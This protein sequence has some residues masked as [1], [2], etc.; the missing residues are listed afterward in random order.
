M[1]APWKAVAPGTRKAGGTMNPVAA[2]RRLMPGR[3]A[4]YN[5][6][7]LQW[8]R[9]LRRL[10]SG[11]A[12]RAELERDCNVPS[13]TKRISEMRRAGWRIDSR[14]ELHTGSDG[15]VNVATVYSMADDNTAQ[16]DLFA[17]A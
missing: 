16:S 8:K 6:T 14:E 2:K 13:A 9:I 12:T 17:P 5:D 15:T 4:P 7:A 3:C 1:F 11:P 10:V